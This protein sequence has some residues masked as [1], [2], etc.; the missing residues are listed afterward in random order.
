MLC[1]LL[2]HTFPV[3][4][5]QVKAVTR[6]EGTFLSVPDLQEIVTLEM[7]PG[8][9]GE[10]TFQPNGIKSLCG[11]SVST[12]QEKDFSN[13]VQQYISQEKQM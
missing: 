5:M 1:E 2:L 9:Y 4:Q 12:A 7:M 6:K 8:S 13:Q 11:L 3:F 10:L